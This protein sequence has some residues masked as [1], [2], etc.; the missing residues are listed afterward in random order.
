METDKQIKIGL[1]MGGSC[2]KLSVMAEQEIPQLEEEVERMSDEEE[3]LALPSQ[4]KQEALIKLAKQ[5]EEDNVIYLKL[6]NNHIRKDKEP[7]DKERGIMKCIQFLKDYNLVNEKSIIQATG[8]GAHKY[9]SLFM[10][11]LGIEVI[12]NDEMESLVK[13]M[14]YLQDNIKDACFTY[15]EEEGKEFQEESNMYPRILVSIGS[16]VSIIKANS[17]D[18]YERVAGSMIGG[19]TLVGLSNLLLHINDFNKI[20]DFS[21][22]GDH[23]V[24]DTIVKDLYDSNIDSLQEDTIATSFGKI[25]TI[26]TD[27]ITES[28]VKQEDIASSLVCMISYNIGQITYLCCKLHKVQKVYFVGNFVK[29]HE[30]TMDR[31]TMAFDFF[32]RKEIKCMYMSHDGFLASIGA[33]VSDKQSNEE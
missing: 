23:T 5:R 15:T 8:G 20:Q 2:V 21:K 31:L 24:V 30:Y 29:Q 32:A 27:D 19:G 17:Q 33:L 4:K 28:S 11:E 25:A 13:G 9:S 10:D 3:K 6:W 18:S 22:K 14:V 16:G 7:S 12:K 26:Q 1:D